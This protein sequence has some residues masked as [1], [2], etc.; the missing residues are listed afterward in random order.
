[1]P[2]PVVPYGQSLIRTSVMPTH[3][4]EHLDHALDAFAQVRKR[5]EI[6]EFDPENLPESDPSK[7][8]FGSNR[9]AK[10]WKDIWGS[11]QGIGS[12][13]KIE[14]VAAMVERLAGEYKAAKKAL[15]G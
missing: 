12:V 5:Y 15:A 13:H 14:P 8:D 2:Y 11:G 4:R 7:M 10:A 9:P 3:T 1:M 6:P